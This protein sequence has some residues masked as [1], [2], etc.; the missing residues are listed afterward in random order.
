MASIRLAFF[1]VLLIDKGIERVVHERIDDVNFLLPV[2][3]SPETAFYLHGL[4]RIPAKHAVIE[5][6]RIAIEV[7]AF[8]D[9]FGAKQDFQRVG[10]IV[11]SL[12]DFSFAGLG[13]C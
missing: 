11:K 12:C 9:G 8:A 6:K 5:D 7:D 10:G 13:R 2:S 4:C 3:L 1:V